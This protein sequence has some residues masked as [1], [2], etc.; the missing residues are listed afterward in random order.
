VELAVQ[1]DARRQGIA[2]TLLTALLRR[3]PSD[4]ALLTTQTDNEGAIA[5]YASLG[6]Q[7]LACQFDGP[8]KLYGQRLRG[9][10]PR[11]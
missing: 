3:A 6:W 11:V 8:W 10:P 5:L 4:R 7:E 2:T 1:P 9:S